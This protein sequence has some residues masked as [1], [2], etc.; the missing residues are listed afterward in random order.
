[1]LWG[2]LIFISLIL[3]KVV[4]ILF[5][6]LSFSNCSFVRSFQGKM[7]FVNLGIFYF[8]SAFGEGKVPL[9]ILLAVL[10]LTLGT[11]I[12]LEMILLCLLLKR[13]AWRWSNKS[14]MAGRMLNFPS[15]NNVLIFSHIYYC[16]SRCIQ[17]RNLRKVYTANKGRC[18][19]VKSLQLT[20]H[21]NQILALLGGVFLLFFIP[22]L[23]LHERE[24]KDRTNWKTVLLL[25][26]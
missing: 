20:L 7:V 11:M 21:E 15:L 19:A 18:C 22:A 17:I 24:K 25:I 9:N 2:I 1:M 14:L 3:L 10:I 23:L 6:H 12:F 26:Y 16:L 8:P 4:Q 5:V 13:W